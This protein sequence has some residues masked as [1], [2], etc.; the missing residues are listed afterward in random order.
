MPSV[1]ESTVPSRCM[2]PSAAEVRSPQR[3]LTSSPLSLPLDNEFLQHPHP[4]PKWVCESVLVLFLKILFCKL[5][6]C[7]ILVFRKRMT[8]HPDRLC[9]FT[10]MRTHL[11]LSRPYL[12]KHRSSDTLLCVASRD[13]LMRGNVT[14][15]AA[16]LTETAG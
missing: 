8:L 4:V 7:V 10:M 2:T 3:S 14:G 1:T 5:Q 15:K 9:P 6:K 12:K 11:L 13:S 16:T